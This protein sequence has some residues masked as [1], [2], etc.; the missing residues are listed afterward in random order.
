MDPESKVQK[1]DWGLQRC[2]CEGGKREMYKVK[3]TR[4]WSGR[5]VSSLGLTGLIFRWLQWE[6]PAIVEGGDLSGGYWKDDRAHK[7][8]T[9]RKEQIQDMFGQQSSVELPRIHKQLFLR[10]ETANC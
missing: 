10:K 3:Y 6:K 7:G 2:E 1:K 9:E 5:Q 8:V 4:G